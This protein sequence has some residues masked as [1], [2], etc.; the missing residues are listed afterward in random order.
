MNKIVILFA[1]LTICVVTAL[2]IKA[3]LSDTS[4]SLRTV[5][6]DKPFFNTPSVLT[7]TGDYVNSPREDFLQSGSYNL[8]LSL[9]QMDGLVGGVAF[10]DSAQRGQWQLA[11]SRKLMTM[12]SSW[13]AIA[14]ASAGLTLSDRRSQVLKASYGIR[15][16]WRLGVSTFLE[17][18]YGDDPGYAT[19]PLIPGS[20]QSFGFQVDTTFKF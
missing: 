12:D 7:L 17:D 18:R 9:D 14:E 11:Y 1:A 8:P 4:P 16:W 6:S 5:L 19:V 2:P 20:G 15:N 3:Q 10:G 13:Q